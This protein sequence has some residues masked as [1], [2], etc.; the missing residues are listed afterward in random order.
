M[1][2]DPIEKEVK[3]RKRKQLQGKCPGPCRVNFLVQTS[4]FLG[5]FVE[6]GA[7]QAGPTAMRSLAQ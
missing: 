4:L 3:G 1:L 6:K 2:H 7:Q 5:Y